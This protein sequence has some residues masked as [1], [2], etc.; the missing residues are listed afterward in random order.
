MDYSP[1]GQLAW[2]T[3][4]NPGDS[5]LPVE[6]IKTLLGR[7]LSAPLARV[8]AAK[9]NSAHSAGTTNKFDR[10][11]FVPWNA[12]RTVVLIRSYTDTKRPQNAYPRLGADKMVSVYFALRKMGFCQS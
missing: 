6:M 11:V 5:R 2:S 4:V 9:I 3:S 8:T 10:R 7:S 12:T 1:L